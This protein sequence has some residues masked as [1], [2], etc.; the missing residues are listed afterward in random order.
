MSDPSHPIW[1]L[2]R[3]TIALLA[4]I[5]ILYLTANVF[6]ETEIITIIGMFAVLAGAEGASIAQYLKNHKKPADPSDH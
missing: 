6:D 5:A 4:L 1:S 2:G 3:M